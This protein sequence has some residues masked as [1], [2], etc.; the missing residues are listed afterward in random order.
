M[1]LDKVNVPVDFGQGLDTKT[2]EKLVEPGKLLRAENVVFKKG[3]TVSK[4][5]GYKTINTD[6][7]HDDGRMPSCRLL[8]EHNGSLTAMS[9]TKL[10]H[11]IES[12]DK[13][14]VIGEKRGAGRA[15][16]VG[17]DRL[18]IA[19]N[20]NN[21]T[22]MDADESEKY[23]AIVSIE[24]GPDKSN[25]VVT[26]YEKISGTI[27][28][29]E[30][31]YASTAFNALQTRIVHVPNGSNDDSFIVTVFIDYG[32]PVH[33][34]SVWREDVDWHVDITQ[35]APM[36]SVTVS[37][38][39][40]HSLVYAKE[41][42]YA[43]LAF[44]VFDSIG[45]R[46]EV[47]VMSIADGTDSPNGH[48]YGYV[49]WWD[50]SGDGWVTFRPNPYAVPNGGSGLVHCVY[51]PRRSRVYVMATHR[52]TGEVR[53]HL[54]GTGDAADEDDI[55]YY[56]DEAGIGAAITYL[57]LVP[58]TNPFANVPFDYVTGTGNLLS[59]A[60]PAL[61][62]Q[63][64]FLDVPVWNGLSVAGNENRK[65]I[66]SKNR[67]V[68]ADTLTGVVK[69][70]HKDAESNLAFTGDGDGWAMFMLG[71]S[72]DF[73]V[74]QPMKLETGGTCAGVEFGPLPCIAKYDFRVD[75]ESGDGDGEGEL[76]VYSSMEWKVGMC[77][78]G[79]PFELA[80]VTPIP[81][82]LQ[83]F[84]P[85]FEN[86]DFFSAKQETPP[87]G[88]KES[89]GVWHVPLA[90]KNPVSKLDTEPTYFIESF[91]GKYLNSVVWG[92][93]DYS[94]DARLAHRQATA[95]KMGMPLNGVFGD[96]RITLCGHPSFTPVDDTQNLI[97]FGTR[98][99]D[100]PQRQISKTIV[101]GWRGLPAVVDK[102]SVDSDA[103]VVIPLLTESQLVNATGPAYK[104]LQSSGVG[105]YAGL[106]ELLVNNMLNAIAMNAAVGNQRDTAQS[107]PSIFSLNYAGEKDIKTCDFG[108]SSFYPGGFLG[109]YDGEA[110]YENGFHSAPMLLGTASEQVCI[111]DSDASN[112]WGTTASVNHIY[113]WQFIWE[114]SDSSGKKHRS[115][116]SSTETHG[117][118]EW[119]RNV[120]NTSTGT[121]T[122]AA[123]ADSL[124]ISN[125]Y[126]LS[127]VTHK[128]FGGENTSYSNESI[129]NP[130]CLVGYRTENLIE[131]DSSLNFFR[132]TG[133]M[134]GEGPIRLEEAPLYLSTSP[135]VPYGQTE[136]YTD[137]VTI[138]NELLYTSGGELE[139]NA[140]P[141]CK[142]IEE[143]D[144]RLFA[145]PLEKENTIM[146]SKKKTS[147]QPV[148]F[149]D[150]FSI[151]VGPSG[152]AITGLSSMDGK[153]VIFK[154]D[155]IYYMTGEGPNALGQGWG[156]SEPML[157]SPDIGATSHKLIAKTSKGLVFMSKRG[158][159]I[160]SRGMQ[161]QYIGAEVERYNDYNFC[162]AVTLTESD[163]VRFM[164]D[165]GTTLVLNTHFGQWSTFTNQFSR[166][167]IEY[168]GKHVYAMPEDTVE[169]PY[170]I[171]IVE[172][173][174]ESYLDVDKPILM[175][176]ETAWIKMSGLKGFQR[177]SWLSALGTFKSPHQITMELSYNYQNFP[178]ETITLSGEDIAT[179]NNYGDCGPFGSLSCGGYGGVSFSSDA[180]YQFRHKPKI[181]K[182]ES[183]KLR[184][185]DNQ[186]TQD[187]DALGEG[188]ELHNI[189]LEVGAKRGQFKLAEKRT[190]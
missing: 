40:Q 121:P 177:V 184:F 161:L 2:D 69:T 171:L 186:Y 76:V 157:I 99:F 183:L 11:R 20:Q 170:P 32:L 51:E 43:I 172:E 97:G 37:P 151:D 25:A 90:R 155:S 50:L 93:F 153:L 182:C 67:C 124:G 152:G 98:D 127:P 95:T 10:H 89:F 134:H 75:G 58:G 144:F 66:N 94:I 180:V 65:I 44:T 19:S 27:I 46:P 130:V 143:H 8:G 145:V 9:D 135:I 187:G 164:S 92:D 175:D 107:S 129:G 133:V 22:G 23:R 126:F 158:I 181:Q 156:Y 83:T 71:Y 114:F 136:S 29:T 91:Y 108:S 14:K 72:R 160:L 73:S 39:G 13:F 54:H 140:P 1:P 31:M 38:S 85:Q 79:Q 53:N 117:R 131:G 59:P 84:F 41:A 78:A 12:E 62:G 119:K 55:D 87:W 96:I 34:G 178:L 169:N 47:Y 49:N 48:P 115:A 188:Y 163:E 112:A 3:G 148:M 16:P 45:I 137:S 147:T 110:F 162:S 167:S 26:V 15:R 18:D 174:S 61:M 118:G 17:I 173:D 105:G 165:E 125:A 88:S 24:G 70:A 138:D 68:Y 86:K 120:L 35:M 64:L 142:I 4:R 123:Y 33:I 166:D 111:N 57:D 103:R 52:D 176:L 60:T 102:G 30:T 168:N 149:S 154:G 21:T 80:E 36:P 101:P 128:N 189:T 63:V 74:R 6:L 122:L 190:V 106:T 28:Y 179:S 139:N 81:E 109:E 146:F 185:K 56:L 5:N 132:Q 150:L 159:Y 113:Q 42:G 100:P 77:L 116:P 82:E 104:P 7:I 141:S